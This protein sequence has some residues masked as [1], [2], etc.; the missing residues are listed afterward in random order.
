[1]STFTF[2]RRGGHEETVEADRV[3][4]HPGHVA[5]YEADWTLVIAVRNEQV[6]DLREQ[7]ET[8]RD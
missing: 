5:F 2:R 8:R 6:N 1:V 7:P 4:F 3:K